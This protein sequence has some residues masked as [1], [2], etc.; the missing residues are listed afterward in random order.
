MIKWHEH[1]LLVISIVMILRP[2]MRPLKVDVRSSVLLL[3]STVCRWLYLQRAHS[4]L[5]GY[6]S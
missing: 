4:G 3:R 5:K 6:G 2:L 1:L